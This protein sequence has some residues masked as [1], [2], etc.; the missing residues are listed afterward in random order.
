VP[1]TIATAR[2][3]LVLL[4]MVFSICQ[5]ISFLL[6]KRPDERVTIPARAISSCWP[7]NEGGAGALP[8]VSCAYAP[9][10]A[11]AE[12][13]VAPLVERRTCPH[14]RKARSV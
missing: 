11:V 14:K 8:C 1:R 10:D 5:L 12:H 13:D 9:A 7:A 3:I 6:S 4:N 2:A